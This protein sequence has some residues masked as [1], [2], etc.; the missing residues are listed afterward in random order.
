MYKQKRTNG[1]IYG[2][3]N[4]S[5]PSHMNFGKMAI[6]KMFKAKDKTA[7]VRIV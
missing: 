7:M 2:D 3:Q 4:F 1:I 5:I 6:D